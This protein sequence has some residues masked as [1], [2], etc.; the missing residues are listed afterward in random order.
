MNVVA[1]GFGTASQAAKSG[2][3]LSELETVDGDDG[4]SGQGNLARHGEIRDSVLVISVRDGV[5]AGDGTAGRGD[6]RT[7]LADV[8]SRRVGL[9]RYVEREKRNARE[10][11]NREEK[12]TGFPSHGGPHLNKSISSL[13]YCQLCHGKCSV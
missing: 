3:G 11:E 10:R 9:A 13:P 1:T 6:R 5:A 7:G 8:E 12:A 4:S 2:D